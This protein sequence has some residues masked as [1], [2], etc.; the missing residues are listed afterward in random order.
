MR[1]VIWEGSHKDDPVVFIST[2]LIFYHSTRK[3]LV[4]HDIQI[5]HLNE[6]NLRQYFAEF[7]PKYIAVENWALTYFDMFSKSFQRDF[8]KNYSPQEV[9]AG[10]TFFFKNQNNSIKPE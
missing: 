10:L 8:E 9:R 2:A 3:G 7:D 6:A 5:E 4:E 1:R